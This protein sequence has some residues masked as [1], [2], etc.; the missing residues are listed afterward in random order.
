M[1]DISIF[2]VQNENKFKNSNGKNI[3]V[4]KAIKDLQ[5]YKSKINFTYSVGVKY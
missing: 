1:K 2:L 5:H 4:I 3:S